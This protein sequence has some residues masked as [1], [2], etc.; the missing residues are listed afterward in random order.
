[1][2]VSGCQFRHI[3]RPMPLRQKAKVSSCDS[4][5]LACARR[6][7]CRIY[8]AVVEEQVKV[9]SSEQHASPR[10]ANQARKSEQAMSLP[11]ILRGNDAVASLAHFRTPTSSLVLSNPMAVCTKTSA[12][13]DRKGCPRNSIDPDVPT[14]Y[15]A[16]YWNAG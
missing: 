16:W 3:C 11:R 7:N 13:N 12:T 14:L 10:K 2:R 15:V 6:S 8:R 4:T 9:S 5:P 1:M